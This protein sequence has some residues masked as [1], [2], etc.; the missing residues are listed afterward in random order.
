VSRAVRGPI[1]ERDQ[2]V[3][4]ITGNRSF[5]KDVWR[6][7]WLEQLARL[8]QRLFVFLAESSQSGKRNELRRQ[9][10]RKWNKPNGARAFW[11]N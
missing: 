1:Q 2:A 10:L 6:W 8:Q 3:K 5:K 7:G 9:G 11:I 4:C